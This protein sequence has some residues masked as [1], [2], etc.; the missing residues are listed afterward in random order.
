MEANL[1]YNKEQSLYFDQYA[2]FIDRTLSLR[3]VTEIKMLLEETKA[4]LGIA[5]LS[6]TKVLTDTSRDYEPNIEIYKTAVSDGTIRLIT[7]ETIAVHWQ[8]G[9]NTK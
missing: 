7:D 3:T 1:E 6:F 5:R 4:F 2:E 8:P 9:A